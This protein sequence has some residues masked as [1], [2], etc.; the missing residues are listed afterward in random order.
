MASLKEVNKGICSSIYFALTIIDP[1]IVLKKFL[2]LPD[3]I[4][5][6]TLY[7]YEPTKIVVVDQDKNFM[8]I[9]F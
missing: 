4:K 5:A 9:A 7:I 6:Q 2:G 3:L 1:K 8:L